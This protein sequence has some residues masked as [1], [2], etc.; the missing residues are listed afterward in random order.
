M[1]LPTTRFAAAAFIVSDAG[2]SI[3]LAVEFTMASYVELPKALAVELP[4][5]QDIGVITV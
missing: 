3:I 1:L 5:T 4:V 2:V